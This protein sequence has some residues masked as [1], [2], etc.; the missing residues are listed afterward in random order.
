MQ[1]P[2]RRLV[3]SLVLVCAVGV[4]TGWL[5]GAWAAGVLVTALGVGGVLRRHRNARSP[6]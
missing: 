5:T 3:G 2:G 1:A 4:L 6:A